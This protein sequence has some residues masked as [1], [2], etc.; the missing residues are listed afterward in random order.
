MIDIRLARA[1]DQ[2]ALE[3]LD[4]AAKTHPG[5]CEEIAAWIAAEQCHVAAVDGA[6]VGYCAIT[7]EF[8][9]RPFIAMLMIDPRYRR[10]GFGEALLI[11]VRSKLPAGD[12]FTSTNA[13]NV[14]MQMLLLKAGFRPS[15]YIDNLDHGDPEVVFHQKVP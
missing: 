4:S 13:S 3:G 9:G 7:A 11:C 2:K 8:F 6:V 5:R 15:G 10:H 14:A 1:A 12:L